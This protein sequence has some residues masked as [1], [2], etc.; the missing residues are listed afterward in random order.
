MLISGSLEV[1]RASVVWLVNQS[2][3]NSFPIPDVL[4]I[5]AKG[6]INEDVDT[7]M[8]IANFAT[9]QSLIFDQHDGVQQIMCY[10]LEMA[11]L[12]ILFVRYC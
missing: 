12:I 4:R 8:Q 6:F 3:L 7:K 10:I 9:K 11:R 5:L 1:S 2:N